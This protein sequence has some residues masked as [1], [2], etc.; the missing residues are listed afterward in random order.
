MVDELIVHIGGFKTG[1]TSIQ[2]ALAS[3]SYVV[4]NRRILYPGVGDK[5]PFDKRHGQH[6]KLARSLM[7]NRPNAKM[8][9]ALFA[10]VAER[11]GRSDADLAVISTEMFEYVSPQALAEILERHFPEY[12]D[13]LRIIGYLRPHAER[14]VSGYAE[15]V[16]HGF[17]Q[18]NLSEFH[19]FLATKTEPHHWGFFYN[20]RFEHWRSV[21]GQRLLLRPMIRSSL[22][23]NDVVADFFRLLFDSENFNMRETRI[24]NVTPSYEDLMIARVF[25]SACGHEGNVSAWQEKMGVALIRELNKTPRTK[26]TTLALHKS[27]AEDVVRVYAQDADKLDTGFLNG[28]YMTTALQAAPEKALEIALDDDPCN[29]LTPEEYRIASAWARAA[30]KG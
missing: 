28:A 17:F 7:P 8:R 22:F 30:D 14:V 19:R 26:R 20:K 21:F 6:E 2:A 27:L 5:E 9:D 25:H 12:R 23:R 24:R 18:G 11:V 15:R 3:K 13:R 10:S 29:V 4:P 1:S 16:K